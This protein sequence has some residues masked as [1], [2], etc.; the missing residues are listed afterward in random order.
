VS[1]F[2]GVAPSIGWRG[3]SLAASVIAGAE[4][5]STDG[6]HKINARITIGNILKNRL[7]VAQ[8]ITSKLL[9]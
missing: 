5:D 4:M 3:C 9:V 6:D 7:I 2:F 8:L 1:E